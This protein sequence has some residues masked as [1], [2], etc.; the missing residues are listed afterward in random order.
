[1]PEPMRVILPKLLTP[2]ADRFMGDGDAT[3]AQQLL[4]VVVAQGKPLVEPDTVA[5]NF[6]RKAVVFVS[7]CVGWRCHAWLPIL[8]FD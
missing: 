2:L 5:N 8:L 1:M 7:L 3:F 6:A 4:H